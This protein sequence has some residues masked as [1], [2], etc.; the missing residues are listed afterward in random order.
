[1]SGVTAAAMAVH[2]DALD[3][4]NLK[5]ALKLSQSYGM[6]LVKRSHEISDL[7]NSHWLGSKPETELH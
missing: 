6:S 4:Q 2:Q 1:M 3:P 5:C 7:H